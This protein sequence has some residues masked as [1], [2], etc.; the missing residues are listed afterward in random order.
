MALPLYDEANAVDL[1]P[2]GEDKGRLQHL[3]AVASSTKSS[4]SSWIC[5]FDEGEGSRSG[6]ILEAMLAYWLS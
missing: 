1:T 4:Y 2:V 3:R 6:L 5:Y